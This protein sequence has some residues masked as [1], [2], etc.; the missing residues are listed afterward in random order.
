MSD[1][2]FHVAQTYFNALGRGDVSTAISCLADDVVWINLPKVPGLSDIIPWLGTCQGT[3]EVAESFR[4]RDAVVETKLFEPLELVVQGEQAVGTIHDQGIVKATELEFDIT[5]ATWMT[6]RGGKI[7]HW[8]SYC[9]P[10][11]IVA[12]FRGDLTARLIAAVS[13]ND[14]FAVEALVK[15]QANP[16]TRDPETGLTVLMMAACRGNVQIVKLLL[17]AGADPLTT[18]SKTGA[19][20]LHKCCQ[21]GN[22]EVARLLL[23]KGA[24][25]DS[26]EPPTGHTPIM[27]ALWYKWPNLVKLL[28]D[29]GQDLNLNTHYGFTLDDHLNFELNVNQGEEK[30]KFVV[31]KEMIDSARARDQRAIQEQTVMAAT[32]KGDTETVRKLISAGADV[33]TLYPHVN[34]FLD[35]HTPLLVAA[36]DGHKEIVRELL[37]AGARVRVEDWVF[38]GSPIHKATYN[39]NPEILKMLIEHPDINLNVQG[40]GNGYTPLHDAL[41][42][43]FTECAQILIDAGARLDLAGHDGKTPLDIATDVYG[44]E[45]EIVKLIRARSERNSS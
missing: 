17:D 19:T 27:V 11:P 32:N 20:A 41:W 14:A 44:P 21:G 3:A 34:S 43:G 6:I 45:A 33:N 26:V 38:K 35:G 22:V 37:K 2:T 25:I 31:I 42:H 8:K 30:Q 23:E 29:Q 7:T 1:G 9:D 18:D 4:V 39:G 15:Q 10:S 36:R 13:R 40:P 12:A 28:V 5:F 24:F 16:N